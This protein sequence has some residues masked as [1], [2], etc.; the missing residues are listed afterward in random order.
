[1]KTSY[2]SIAFSSD[3][4]L[5]PFNTSR[6]DHALNFPQDAD[7]IILAGDIAVGEQASVEAF[8]LAE[9]YPNSHIVRITGNH[10]FYYSGIEQKIEQYRKACADHDRVHFLEN[11]CVELFGVRF[12]GCTLWTD[13]TIL[14]EPELAMQEAEAAIADFRFIESRGGASIKPKD[15]ARKFEESYRFLDDQLAAGNPDRTVVITH[16]PPGMRTRNP[17]FEVDPITAYFQ[18]NVDYLIENYQPKIWVYGHNH[19]SA[20]QTVGRTRI[21]SN[22]LGYPSEFGRIPAYDP[23]KLIILETGADHD[24]EL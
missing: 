12:I 17:N 13:F 23:Q 22:Q 7:V 8:K 1:M 21:V 24:V 19:Y 20:D 11:A 16:F 3:L 10:E 2:I 18:A 4:H 9:T 6:R 14:G 5:A 15:I